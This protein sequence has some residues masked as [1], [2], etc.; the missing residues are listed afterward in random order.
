MLN[1][2]KI[3]F[4]TAL[5]IISTSYSFADQWIDAMRYIQN[6]KVVENSQSF[7]VAKEEC[8]NA[9]NQLLTPAATSTIFSIAWDGRGAPAFK[10]AANKIKGKTKIRTLTQL[11]LE[12][13]EMPEETTLSKPEIEAPVVAPPPPPMVKIPKEEYDQIR[14]DLANEKA[15]VAIAVIAQKKA[16]QEMEAQLLSAADHLAAEKAHFELTI[17]KEQEEKEAVKKDAETQV[18]KAKKDLA[19]QKDKSVKEMK[20]L[21]TKTAQE[22]TDQKNKSVAE[23]QKITA[24]AAKDLAAEKEKSTEAAK[25]LQKAE[26][27]LAVAESKIKLVGDL[28]KAIAE[29]ND[30]NDESVVIATKKLLLAIKNKSKK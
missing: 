6:N 25:C 2:K 13:G 16:E 24:Q 19:Q 15:K 22:L 23:I 28:E 26:A 7:A 21:A 30:T 8:Q 17:K 29:V 18:Q 11:Q 5:T 10:R 3:P 20:N 14:S 27:D 9:Q 4:I 1:I 12:V